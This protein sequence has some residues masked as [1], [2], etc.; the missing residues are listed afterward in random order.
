MCF[1]TFTVFVFELY[2]SYGYFYLQIPHLQNN[3]RR[4]TGSGNFKVLT[5]PV[6][7][8]GFEMTLEVA[9]SDITEAI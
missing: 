4:Q 8:A 1:K 3:P 6:G 2:G 9:S 5:S 7:G